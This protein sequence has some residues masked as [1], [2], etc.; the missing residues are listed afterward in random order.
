MEKILVGEILSN[1]AVVDRIR[2]KLTIPQQIEYMRDKKGI[3]FNIISE[4]SAA[5]FL[6]ESNYYFKL[7]AFEKNYS[8]NLYSQSQTTVWTDLLPPCGVKKS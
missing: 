6:R 2:P 4:D 3:K 8:K 7:K 1:S 5:E